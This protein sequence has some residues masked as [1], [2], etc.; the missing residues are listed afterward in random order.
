VKEHTIKILPNGEAIALYDDDSFLRDLGEIE[1]RRASRVE[2]DQA[3]QMWKVQLNH[4][5]TDKWDT[6]ALKPRRSDAIAYE[7]WFLNMMLE[8]GWINPEKFFESQ[9]AAG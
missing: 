5:G 3:L 2:F 9:E 8:E 6:I 7:I 4:Q 1:V